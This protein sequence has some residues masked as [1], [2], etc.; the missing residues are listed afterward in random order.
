VRSAIQRLWSSDVEGTS[1]CCPVAT[2]W[3]ELALTLLRQE[4]PVK[5]GL[6][7]QV[8]STQVEIVVGERLLHHLDPRVEVVGER[9]L[10][11]FAQRQRMGQRLLVGEHRFAI[12]RRF[13]RAFIR[14]QWL[15]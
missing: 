15:R 4:G 7:E 14:R 2:D 1:D 3:L 6:R 11:G 10:E 8:E 12:G 5:R 13:R 9:A